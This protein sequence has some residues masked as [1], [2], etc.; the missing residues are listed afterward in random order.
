MFSTDYLNNLRT[1]QIPSLEI[2]WN[3][4]TQVF[5]QK[6]VKFAPYM[7]TLPNNKYMYRHLIFKL[8]GVSALLWKNTTGRCLKRIQNK[9]FTQFR[10]QR[11]TNSSWIL[12]QTALLIWFPLLPQV[13]PSNELCSTVCKVIESSLPT[14]PLCLQSKHFFHFWCLQRFWT[15]FCLYRNSDFATVNIHHS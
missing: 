1:V 2:K 4:E 15:P 12:P 3:P 6:F 7:C 9:I 14:F 10:K 13:P 11:K 8:V 5:I